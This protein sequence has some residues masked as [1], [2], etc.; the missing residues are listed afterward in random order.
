MTLTIATLTV[1]SSTYTSP[2][3]MSVAGF[4]LM[5]KASPIPSA[6]SLVV[7]LNSSSKTLTKNGE[8]K[9]IINEHT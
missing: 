2:L 5:T 4:Q 7:V 8:T 6:K 9:L 3:V 1:M